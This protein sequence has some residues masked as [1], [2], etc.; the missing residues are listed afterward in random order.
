MKR[1]VVLQEVRKM[2]FVDV[3]GRWSAGRLS[4]QE[5]A[6]LLGVGER[7]FRRWLR[8][9][10]EEGAAGLQDR[11]IGRPSPRRLPE[12]E[13]ER[14]LT[15]YR[16]HH[17]GWTVKHFH[18]HLVR[19]HRFGLS[20]GWTKTALQAAGLVRR[21]A[22][23]GAHRKRRLRRPL[24]G[25][26]LHQDGSPHEWLPG[27]K[28]DLIIT[29]DDATSEIY[30]AFLV[31]EEGTRSSF[32]ALAEVI[33]RHGLFCALYTDRGSHYFTTPQAGGPANGAPTQVGRAL[34]QLAIQH[35]AAYS[36]QA[37]GRCERAFATLQDRLPKEL[38]LA[39]I[40]GVET[41]NR[42]I[43]ESYLPRHNA[44]FAVAAAEPGTAFVAD[45][46][47][48]ARDVLC[49]QEERQVGN[50]NTVRYRGLVLQ[51]PPSPLRPHFVR[52]TVRVHDYPD[53]T[54]AVFHGP[55][56]LARYTAKGELVDEKNGA[57]SVRSGAPRGRCAALR[58]G[59]AH[60]PRSEAADIQCAT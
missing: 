35:I 34:R 45:R 18:E 24:P 7:T 37:R 15:L 43:A 53:G 48:L 49:I 51:L 22:R 39:G 54:L 17:A 4:Q 33:A 10:E 46:G 30:A 32:A 26:M 29:L 5:A 41:A 6:E 27:R 55:R 8:R 25:M 58:K 38:A 9:Y 21:A 20:Y 36:P 59:S 13:I 42:F 19:E 40:T 16:R 57:A 3:H 50:D 23:R 60:R 12:A 56:Q 11:R 44:R 1:A 31:E 47:G 28:L 14:V 52:A 2:R